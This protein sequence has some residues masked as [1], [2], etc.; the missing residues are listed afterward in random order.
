[1][2]DAALNIELMMYENQI[3]IPY[4][5]EL[6]AHCMAVSEPDLDNEVTCLSSRCSNMNILEKWIPISTRQIFSQKENSDD[7]YQRLKKKGTRCC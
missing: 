4:Q 1:M 3:Q 6:P 5:M 2:L 7:G